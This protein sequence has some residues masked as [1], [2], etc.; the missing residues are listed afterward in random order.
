MVSLE[1]P[2]PTPPYR[3]LALLPGLKL[4]PTAGVGC[5][6]WRALGFQF[7]KIPPQA[8]VWSLRAKVKRCQGTRTGVLGRVGSLQG[9]GSSLRGSLYTQARE[10]SCLHVR[11]EKAGDFQGES[12]TC[13]DPPG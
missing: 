1:H 7:K 5:S 11:L 13:W 12:L 2:P 10:L 4:R 8:N 6:C 9:R 3:L